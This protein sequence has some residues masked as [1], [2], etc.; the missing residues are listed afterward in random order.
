MIGGIVTEAERIHIQIAHF[1]K[2]YRKLNG[3]TQEQ[4]AS[5]LDVSTTTICEYENTSAKNRIK[6]SLLALENIA[7]LDRSNIT[8][9]IY[10]LGTKNVDN[11]PWK[12]PLFNFYS[13]LSVKNQSN[14]L[15]VLKKQSHQDIDDSFEL[16]IAITK[17]SK[18]SRDGLKA[19]MERL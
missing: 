10:R 1:L 13:N 9:F 19:F 7:K 12:R 18:R 3:L 15:R 11:A 5:L 2:T 14:L 8:E 16:F 4:L 17:L 6:S